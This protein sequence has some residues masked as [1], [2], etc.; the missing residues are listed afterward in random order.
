MWGN[1]LVMAAYDRGMQRKRWLL[2]PLAVWDLAWRF[3][4]VR[5]ALRRHE[6]KWA[7]ALALVNSAG[8][9]PMLY[10]ARHRKQRFLG[11]DLG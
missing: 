3:K 6:Y 9:L 2:L 8:V 5:L 11:I 10:I 4:A 1:C 7:L